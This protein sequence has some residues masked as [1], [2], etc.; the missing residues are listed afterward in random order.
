MS[1][2]SLACRGPVAAIVACLFAMVNSLAAQSAAD[3]PA[4]QPQPRQNSSA[5]RVIVALP[6]TGPMAPVGQSAR[7]GL[8]LAASQI[9]QKGG[10]AGHPVELTV[11]D[12]QTLPNQLAD[13]VTRQAVS[14]QSDAVIGGLDGPAALAVRAVAE[15]RKLLFLVL[16][17]NYRHPPGGGH[18]T[19]RVST[20]EIELADGLA[21]FAREDLHA[22]RASAVYDV[23]SEL[24][25]ASADRFIDQF[26]RQ[27]GQMATISSVVAGK[28]GGAFAD[29]AA[30]W[31]S[32]KPDAVFVGLPAESMIGLA[33]QVRAKQPNVPI[34]TVLPPWISAPLLAGNCADVRPAYAAVPFTPDDPDESVSRFLA[35]SS[36][37][38]AEKASGK[39][40]G[41]K[42]D[43]KLAGDA[44][45]A[46]AYD[47]MMLLAEAVRRRDR[48]G[49]DLRDRLAGIR[50][51][52]GVLGPMTVSE[53]GQVIRPVTICKLA[54][55]AK[56]GQPAR[57]VFVRRVAPGPAPAATSQPGG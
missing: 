21:R 45:A 4:S 1:R 56:A 44:Y 27:G 26:S 50:D 36:A 54:A 53:T 48:L 6:L 43:P 13:L 14:D 20:S 52:P 41:E 34:L 11:L 28:E 12:T 24:S 16:D 23:S 5:V 22:A 55:P 7:R 31:V 39:G 42:A 51:L 29:I 18:Y 9:N 3:I 57:L 32:A 40:A 49:G 30:R 46:T 15:K 25:T 38:A 19:C 17:G 47:S 35:D 8:E 2:S 33:G 10:A 37:A